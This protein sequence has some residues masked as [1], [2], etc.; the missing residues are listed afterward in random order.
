MSRFDYVREAIRSSLILTTSYVDGTIIEN[1][2]DQN[3]AILNVNFTKGSLTSAEVKVA[4]TNSL[5]Y[6]LAYDG[7]TVNFTVG[8][9]VIGQTT[10]ARANIV[11]DSDAGA[12]GTLTISNIKGTFLDDETMVDTSGGTAVVNG[13]ITEASEWYQETYS[14]VSGGTSSESLGEH[15]FTASGLFRIAVPIKDRHMKVSSKGTGTVTNSLLAI[16]ALVGRS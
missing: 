4:F 7:Q 9:E 3:Q 12:T 8:D 11:S 14:S 16:D 2:Q 13:T 1:I 6:T 15:A 5:R 10:G